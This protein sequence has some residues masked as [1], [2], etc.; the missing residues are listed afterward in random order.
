MICERAPVGVKK[1]VFESGTPVEGKLHSGNTGAKIFHEFHSRWME[2]V[3]PRNRD[4]ML[5][6]VWK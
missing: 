1:V 3:L 4:E 6:T 5:I 2:T